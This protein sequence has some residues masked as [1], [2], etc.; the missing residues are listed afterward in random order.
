MELLVFPSGRVQIAICPEIAEQL[1]SRRE[2]FSSQHLLDLLFRVPPSLNFLIGFRMA[3]GLFGSNANNELCQLIGNASHC[4][5]TGQYIDI[6]QYLRPSFLIE[7][8]A[9][10]TPG[11]SHGDEPHPPFQNLF[12]IAL[13]NY[14]FSLV[15]LTFYKKHRL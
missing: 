12:F 11:F 4:I 3:M 14:C 10:E 6:P 15:I 1:G 7:I 2:F 9:A 13:S 5:G 8:L